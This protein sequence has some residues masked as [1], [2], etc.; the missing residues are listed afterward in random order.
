MN[1]VARVRSDKIID[2]LSHLLHILQK[3]FLF[4]GLVEFLLTLYE[5][6]HLQML[7][8]KI[9]NPILRL[10]IVPVMLYCLLVKTR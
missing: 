1:Y 7:R 3:L 6:I 10:M 2:F 9:L 4:P 5:V 8:L